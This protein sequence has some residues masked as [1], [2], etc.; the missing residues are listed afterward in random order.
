[1]ADSTSISSGSDLIAPVT[2]G[3]LDS[4]KGTSS[5]KKQRGGSELGKDEFL[6]LLVT[7][8]KYQDPLSPTDN[9]QMV[10]QLAQFSALEQMQNVANTTL[11]S[12]AFGLIGKDVIMTVKSSTGA[13]SYKEGTVDFVTKSGNNT[14]LSIEGNLYNIDDLYS[15]VGDH[16]V[17]LQK[18]P[19]VTATELA[20]D[21]E[22]PKDQQ[23][24]VNLGKEEYEASAVAVFING[25]VVSSDYLSYDKDKEILTISK[26]AFQYVEEGEYNIAF[27]FDD[28]LTTTYTDKVTIKIKGKAKEDP[29]AKQPSVTETALAYNKK[30]PKDQEIKLSLGSDDSAASAVSAYIK[31]QKIDEKYLSYDKDK[32][33]LTVNKDAFAGLDAGEYKVVLM[34]DDALTTTC[35][36]KVTV[37]VID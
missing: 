27:M 36:D 24:E 7:Q 12:Q 31:G 25:K 10:A 28:P 18:V 4:A 6:Q 9:T 20:Y 16:Y 15:V 17:A 35:S 22:N 8:M 34:F 13:T 32:E 1:M 37:K 11:Q 21:H 3:K 23:V 29:A 2:D 19:T 14:Y 33:V 26:D 5:T 30:D